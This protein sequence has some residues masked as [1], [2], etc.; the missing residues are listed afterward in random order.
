MVS[1]P[2]QSP[3]GL[4]RFGF[5]LN[6]KHLHPL[7]I[8]FSPP[9][10][11]ISPKPRSRSLVSFGIS[12]VGIR[13][14][15]GQ[16]KPRTL[17][18]GGYKRPE[19]K[20]P[21]LVLEVGA[22]EVLSGGDAL[23]KVDL[24]VS[25]WV[26]IVVLDG[27][28]GSGGG[29]KLY[30]AAVLLKSVVRDRAALMVM[31]RVDIA[32]AVNANGVV[33]SDQGLPT[34]VA[35]NA[36]MD[37][38]AQTVMLPLVAKKVQTTMAALSASNSEG[39]DFLL[40]SPNE[41]EDP[42]DLM[43]SLSRSIKVPV[44]V[45]CSLPDSGEKLLR[46]GASGLVVSLKELGRFSEGSI[47][48]LIS[49]PLKATG[50]P[51]NDSEGARI[52]ELR[53]SYNGSY[54]EDRV[55]GIVE[56]REKKFVEK[57]KVVLL[58]AIDVIKKAAPL[59]EEVTLL[60]DAVA[61][62]DELF[63]LVIVGEFNSGKSSVINALLGS[64]YMKE[65]VVP[66]TNEITFLKFSE[67]DSGEQQRC[68]RHP[69]GQYICY[70]PA[71][72][73]KEMNIVDTPGTNVILQRQQRLTEEFLPR[74][75]LLLFV[76]S[77][78]RPLTESEVTFLR[79]TQQWRKKI[80][81]VLN[82]S[83]LY[84]NANE[85]EEAI[86]FV[87]ENTQKLLNTDQVTLYPVSARSA[88][89]AKL[90]ASADEPVYEMSDSS[91][92]INRFDEL[93][94]F[95]YSFLDGNSSM[96]IERMK[97]KLETPV[98]IADRLLT[99][100]STLARQEGIRAK[101]DLASVDE[102]VNS[103]KE[104]ATRLEFEHASWKRQ[105]LSLIETTKSRVVN[106]ILSTL[107]ISNVD[108][109]ISYVF[110]GDKTISTPAALRLQNDIIGPAHADA[111]RILGE[112][113]SWLNSKNSRERNLFKD[114]FEK[115]WPRILHDAADT[116]AHELLKAVDEHSMSAI[117]EFSASAA[118]KLFEQEVQ[119]V[120]LG[121]FG[122]VGSAGLSA[123]LLT[124]V[125]P[126]TMEDLLALGLCSAG[127][128]YAV[129]S[130]SFRRRKLVNKVNRIAESLARELDEAMQKDLAKAISD[131]ENFVAVTSKPYKNAAQR[132]ID[133]VQETQERISQ[134]EKKLQA[135][136]IEI[137]NLHVS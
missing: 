110:K 16:Q 120:F 63:L 104:Y 59:M 20:V 75:D 43:S 126:S 55:V 130:F 67:L 51:V 70:L 26:G 50:E 108:L 71:T 103:V 44:F 115:K 106:V 2:C 25:R 93:E 9:R 34:I 15:F 88:L 72:I 64:R 23:D 86:S 99:S 35:R 45:T 131:L 24:A 73:L 7:G 84:Q 137:Q 100:C 47:T 91:S 21:N 31:D 57:E 36:M 62:L 28:G 105:I 114:S 109:A 5:Q 83:D 101:Q 129:A 46:S 19:I 41:D 128:Y 14:E 56:G 134:V 116:E 122:G 96:G 40:L 118:S 95:L 89:R 119:E 66:T 123:S 98:A 102:L 135:L 6:S 77:A 29:G 37:G 60:T 18:P 53:Q 133:E 90:S 11:Q 52:V 113:L 38:K 94:K 39:A 82:K 78:D 27:G 136:Q 1:L 33:L 58:E 76:I 4:H 30:E 117:G 12:R 127:G 68:E 121:T 92:R 132:R 3:A 32:A 74:A 61:Q 112:Y 49:T 111:Q 125:L 42:V 13:S 69:D 81:F 80:V 48:S 17:F 10:T 97:L 8:Q 79:Y 65:G 124:S 107:K 85:L 54:W 87:K 22:E